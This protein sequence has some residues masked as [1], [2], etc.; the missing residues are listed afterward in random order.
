MRADN[1]HSFNFTTDSTLTILFVS[2]A[3]FHSLRTA[4]QVIGLLMSNVQRFIVLHLDHLP[5]GKEQGFH[6]GDASNEELCDHILYYNELGA[7]RSYPYKSKCCYNCEAAA[8]FSGLCTA[9][10][11]I[12]STVDTQLLQS[13]ENGTSCALGD[14]STQEVYL[15]TCTLVFIPLER[16]QDGEILAVAQLKRCSNTAIQMTQEEQSK[17]EVSPQ[18]MRQSIQKAHELFTLMNRGGIYQSLTVENIVEHDPKVETDASLPT[19]QNNIGTITIYD[20]Q[21]K[22]RELRIQ[23][24]NAQD[25]KEKNILE[26]DIHELD[27]LLDDTEPLEELRTDLKYYYDSFLRNIAVSE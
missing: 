10:Y 27:N 14:K 7:G 21:Q 19:D 9:L 24:Q 12:Q 4:T 22:L 15:S 23:Y 20:L 5:G 1:R 26:Q 6:D 16:L 25:D 13:N 11:S 2:S 18:R 3:L 17:A 8:K